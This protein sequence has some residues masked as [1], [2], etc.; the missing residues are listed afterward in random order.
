MPRSILKRGKRRRKNKT[1]HVR[2]KRKNIIHTIRND[3]SSWS[4]DDK[5]QLDKKTKSSLV[6]GAW[7]ETNNT[8][9]AI[10]TLE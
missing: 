6:T 1:R 10:I 8:Q 2:F 7:N 5:I 3:T 4:C 9:L